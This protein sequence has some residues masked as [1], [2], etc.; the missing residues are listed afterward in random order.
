[1]NRHHVVIAALVS[2]SA[3]LSAHASP[4]MSFL[5]APAVQTEGAAQRGLLQAREGDRMVVVVKEPAA[6]GERMS[7][8]RVAVI[9]GVVHVGFRVPAAGSAAPA[10]LATGI[11]TLKGV[12]SQPLFVLAEADRAAGLPPPENPTPQP[13]MKFLAGEARPVE[14]GARASVR[15]VRYG[16]RMIAVVTEPA[17]CG[18][19]LADPAVALEQSKLVLR[20]EAAAPAGEARP[21]AATAVFTVTGLPSRDMGAVARPAPLRHLAAARGGASDASGPTMR[22]QGVPAVAAPAMQA[23]RS[24]VQVRRGDAMSVIIR[25]PA[26]CGE[27]P[28][29]ASFQLE[30]GRLWVRYRMPGA[31]PRQGRCVATAMIAFRG[32]PPDELRVVAM[33]DSMPEATLA[34]DRP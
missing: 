25:E 13:A 33:S 31:Q 1:M 11:F 34:M 15:Q 3:T 20:Y 19:R 26:A 12:P 27:R 18:S 24:V 30:R 16:D 28:D 10:C 14:G 9:E 29:R 6:C 7:A 8:A 23:Q 17:A 32:L 2:A 5:A 22:F 4:S 21:C